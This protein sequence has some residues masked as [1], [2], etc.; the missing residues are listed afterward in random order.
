MKKVKL[1]ILCFL[2]VCSGLT[3]KT[4]ADHTDAINS[5]VNVSDASSLDW[6]LW[7]YRPNVWRMNFNFEQLTGS[8]AEHADIPMAVPGSIQQALKNAGVIEDWNIGINSRK[9]EWIENRHWLV[10]A[11]I[12]NEWLSVKEGEKII[13]E[14]LGLDYKGILMVNGHEAGR[15]ENTF[16]PYNFDISPFIKES[17]NIVFVFEC[18]PENLAQ[19]GWTSKITEWKSRFNYGWDWMPRIVQTGIW[20]KVFIHKVKEEQPMLEDLKIVA[21]ADKTKD[22]GGLSVSAKLNKTALSQRIHVTLTGSDG[23]KVIEETFSADDLSRHKT[24]SNLKIKRWWP[25]DLGEQAL[26]TLQIRLIDEKGNQ[27][28][29]NTKRI[30]FR[31]IEWT[32]CKGAPINADPWICNVND[33]PV[34]LQGINWTPIRPNFADLQIEDYTKRLQLYK[35]MGVNTIRIWG[36]GFPEKEWL[37]DL[38]DEMGILIWQDFPLSS[39]GLDDYPPEGLQ[40]VH[41]ISQIATHYV[42][43]LYHHTSLLLW[44]GGNELYERDGVAPITD[45]HVMIK[46]MKDVVSLHDPTRRFVEASPSGPSIYGSYDT[47]GA[48]KN[49]DVH[50]PWDL[51]YTEQDKT[52]NAVEDFWSKDDAMFRSEVGVPGAMSVEM[53][54][55]YKGE[56]RLLPA[57]MENPLWRNVSWWLQWDE[58]KKTGKNTENIYEYVNW[59]Q[60]RQTEGLTSAL[61]KCKDRFPACGGFIIWMGHDSYPCMINTSLIDFDG[62]TKPVA[63]ELSKIWKDNSY[64]KLKTK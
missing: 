58:Y 6:R 50:G 45:K 26:Y 13:V 60:N 21:S 4:Y 39:S 46:A 11:K 8:W 48:G 32:Q 14:C 15:F 10:V 63:V 2:Y 54:N 27:L 42:K 5:N 17:N 35:E 49:W 36:G 41:M 57:S 28:Q 47:F 44:C 30:G 31:H 56:F 18:P 7:C 9:I 64:L 1:F 33:Q 12:P 52:M 22:I 59:S 20:D 34:F 37:Y 55:K 61:K 25:N 29:Q 53:M 19:I 23:K 40:E 24:W 38:C 43:R 62:N 16:L 51:P 3:V